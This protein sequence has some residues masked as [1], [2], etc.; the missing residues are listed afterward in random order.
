M[1][2]RSAFLVL[3]CLSALEAIRVQDV[4]SSMIQES[5]EPAEDAKGKET[6]D[7]QGMIVHGV[8]HLYQ[9]G[10]LPIEIV[11]RLCGIAGLCHA[12]LQGYFPWMVL[13]FIFGVFCELAGTNAGFYCKADTWLMDK[14]CNDAGG[15]HAS[16][17]M[18]WFYPSVLAIHRLGLPLLIRPVAA[19]LLV[20]MLSA[21]F[22][23]L[24]PVAGWWYFLTPLAAITSNTT[25][26][27]VNAIM[28]HFTVGCFCGLAFELAAKYGSG[29]TEVDN[30]YPKI[31]VWIQMLVLAPVP[32]LGVVVN[33]TLAILLAMV[34]PTSYG[35]VPFLVLVAV[36]VLLVTQQVV[37]NGIAP[38]QGL[39]KDWAPVAVPLVFAGFVILMALLSYFDVF[40]VKPADLSTHGLDYGPQHF[41]GT[42]TWTAPK[43]I[44]LRMIGLC[45]LSVLLSGLVHYK[46]FVGLVP[47]KT[48]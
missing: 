6:S 23:A 17:W 18:F 40:V 42:F 46:A 2:I 36:A 29:S 37:Q 20:L 44:V 21:P 8:D 28:Q 33:N 45:T 19:G 16:F 14:P 22:D 41:E 35:A 5:A 4:P 13:T 30:S 7:T 12:W 1:V 34:H 15:L 11:L 43:E 3:L 47:S 32:V 39:G 24:G 48:K 10:V 27:V 38:K 26:V 25:T 9:T 31:A